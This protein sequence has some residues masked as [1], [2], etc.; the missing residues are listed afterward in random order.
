MT[1]A[2]RLPQR[3]AALLVTVALLGTGL[4]IHAH[5]GS[6]SSGVSVAASPLAQHDA[7]AISDCSLCLAR[8][9]ARA[10]LAE[11]SPS[12]CAAV[13]PARVPF[14]RREPLSSQDH[15]CGPASPRA[16]PSRSA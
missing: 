6:P 12:A 5:G 13:T 10:A 16:P 14:L 3:L 4:A 1:Q 2:S 11:A 15:A 8:S 7:D 9:Q